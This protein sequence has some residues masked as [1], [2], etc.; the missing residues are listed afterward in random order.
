MYNKSQ[1]TFVIF[2]I[3]SLAEEWKKMPSE[4]YHILNKSGILDDYI[5]RCYDT[6]HTLGKQY[7]VEDV[8]EFVREKGVAV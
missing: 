1:L 6:L 3:Y 2:V 4:V 7:L 5:I 8:T